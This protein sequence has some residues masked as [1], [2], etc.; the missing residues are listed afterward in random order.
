MALGSTQ[1]LT[2][3][4]TRNISSGRREVKEVRGGRCVGLTTLP[5][6]CADCHEIWEPQ[7]PGTLR[8][9]PGLYKYWFTFSLP[10]HSNWNFRYNIYIYMFV[11]SHMIR[12]TPWS[13][14]VPSKKYLVRYNCLHIQ[15]DNTGKVFGRKVIYHFIPMNALN[16]YG[17]SRGADPLIFNIGARR[18][19]MLSFTL[20]SVFA[21]RKSSQSQ[22]NEE[23]AGL[24][25][26]IDTLKE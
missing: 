11:N 4:S 24:R 25:G 17:G 23:K 15:C 6:L 5:H 16:A 19:W 2:E 1:L 9:C 26:S 7:L 13:V 20:R 3:M 22:L 21:R 14:T 18:R 12:L 10:N 8:S